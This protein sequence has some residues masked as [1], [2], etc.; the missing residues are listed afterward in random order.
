M[1]QSDRATD[2][3]APLAS[4][5]HTMTTPAIVTTEDA[6]GRAMNATTSPASTL[7]LVITPAVATTSVVEATAHPNSQEGVTPWMRT[8]K[9]QTLTHETDTLETQPQQEQSADD[10]HNPRIAF[11]VKDAY[12]QDFEEKVRS[13]KL[14]QEQQ[15]ERLRA[16]LEEQRLKHCRMYF[17]VGCFGLPLLLFINVIQHYSEFKTEFG[18]FRIRKYLW[19]SLIVGLLESFMWILWFTVFRIMEPDSLDSL[20]IYSSPLSLWY[21]I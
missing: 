10:N 16:Q 18:S 6:S 1:E 8:V 12:R 5:S 4:T 3:T 2:A 14:E 15:Q 7:P 21:L 20:S 13:H 19:L 17:I 11:V 9:V